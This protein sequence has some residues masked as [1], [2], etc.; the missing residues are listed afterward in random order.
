MNTSGSLGCLLS[1]F[2]P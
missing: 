1:G 2:K